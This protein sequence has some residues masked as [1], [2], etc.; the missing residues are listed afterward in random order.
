MELRCWYPSS[1]LENAKNLNSNCKIVKRIFLKNMVLL[2]MLWPKPRTWQLSN[3]LSFVDTFKWKSGLQFLS[4]LNDSKYNEPKYVAGSRKGSCY[5]CNDFGME[6]WC[7]LFFV[8]CCI[9][10]EGK[11][12]FALKNY[13]REL[14]Q[15]LWRSQMIFWWMLLVSILHLRKLASMYDEIEVIREEDRH[16]K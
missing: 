12:K 6:M 9:T 3:A 2:L 5:V 14:L 1:V 4:Q 13:N 8:N 7:Y 16:K 15:K 11:V 10:R